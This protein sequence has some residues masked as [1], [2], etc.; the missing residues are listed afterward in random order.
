M[1]VSGVQGPQ[2]TLVYDAEQRL[3]SIVRRVSGT[4]SSITS[5]YAYDN[6]DRLTTITHS[7]SQ[8]G[9]LATYV[10][11]WNNASDLTSYTGP[12]GNL[13]YTYDAS[14][15]LIAVGGA[16][17]ENYSYDLN[18]NRTMTG[19]TTGTGNR[20]TGDG[21]YTYAYD[22]E[23]NQV[24]KTRLSDNENWT[25]TW[26]N[27]NRLTQVVE[28]TSAGVTVTNDVFTYDVEDRRIGKSVNGTQVWF[29]Y[30]GQN[31][32]A[33]FNA[34]G[35]LTMRYLTGKAL[36]SLYARYDGTNTGW[37]LTDGLGSLR[38]IAN[39]S[40]IVLDQL[41]YDGYG[42]LLSESNA[43]NGDRFKFEAREWDSELR[44]QYNRHRY[45]DPGTGRWLSNDPLGFQSHDL[46]LYRFVNNQATT[47]TDPLGLF[48]I[49]NALLGGLYGGVTGA[50]LGSAIPPAWGISQGAGFAI[51]FAVGFIAGGM[52]DNPVQAAANGVV[53]SAASIT[54]MRFVLLFESIV[55]TVTA[56]FGTGL[57]VSQVQGAADR[58]GV[59]LSRVEIY[60][61]E[62][63]FTVGLAQ[64]LNPA[65][66]QLLAAY[67][68]QQGATSAT[69]ET[70]A[71][72]P[73]LADLLTNP[74]A[75]QLLLGNSSA[76]ATQTGSITLGHATERTFQVTATLR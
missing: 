49:N 8:A 66:I 11:A 51:G 67:L 21:T 58:L 12:E 17:T 45:Y 18:G 28:K 59:N 15:E 47:R 2:V 73:R 37:Y 56:R 16:R 46:N 35:S 14:R 27:R 6:A 9:A 71:Y 62:A 38:L 64:N 69:F 20:L 7:S 63:R 25:F 5:N 42:N 76:Q 55:V 40:G 30:D 36:D 60:N 41:T 65:D 10:Y 39:P 50:I 75:V 43:T 31:S 24:S 68:R 70:V 74:R 13:T 3:T 23:G 44:L 4:G 61:H 33:D 32:Y 53:A 1:K 22:A 52:T 72:N 29:G 48:N 34:A 26:D 19:Y 57:A 54:L